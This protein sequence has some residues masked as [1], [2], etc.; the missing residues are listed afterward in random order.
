MPPRPKRQGISL[1]VPAD[2]KKVSNFPKEFLTQWK[3]NGERCVVENFHG[4]PLLMS[5]YAD[6]FEFLDHIRK[7][8]KKLWEK[9]GMPIKFDGEL[10]KHGWKRERI[11]SAVSRTKNYNPDVEQI[12]FHI[13]DIKWLSFNQSHRISIL[14]DLF[15]SFIG[16][17]H[18]VLKLVPTFTATSENWMDFA[19]KFLELGYEGSV[20]RNPNCPIYY[21]GRTV[22]QMLKYK[23][24]EIDEYEIVGIEEAISQEGEPK[25]MVGS[26]IVKA[27]DGEDTFSVGAGKLTHDLRRH[28]WFIQSTLMGKT[29]ITKQGKILTANGFPT[30]AVAVEV[31]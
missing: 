17:D 1:C 19:D 20:L 5:S 6:P 9:F 27:H 14:N 21:A 31:K 24:T 13:F 10:Y 29:L 7:P 4:E 3:L 15:S 12:E 28:Y 16:Q 26:F 30:C 23:P 25:N 11:H 22:Y 8:I 2:E 18:P